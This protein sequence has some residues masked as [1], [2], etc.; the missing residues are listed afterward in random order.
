MIALS[1]GMSG[2]AGHESDVTALSVPRWFTEHRFCRSLQGVPRRGAGVRLI[3][4]T[5]TAR[6][7][8]FTALGSLQLVPDHTSIPASQGQ[9]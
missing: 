5:F 6:S 1:Y 8:P 9:R 3:E 4:S 2:V 7:K